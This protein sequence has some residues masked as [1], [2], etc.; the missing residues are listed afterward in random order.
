M[1][2]NF[3]PFYSWISINNCIYRGAKEYL[4]FLIDYIKVQT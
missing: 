3:D 4:C 2:P 1:C